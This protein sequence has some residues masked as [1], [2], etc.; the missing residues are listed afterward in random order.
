M[1]QTILQGKW[2]AGGKLFVPFH[3]M[4]STPSAD[5][6]K[7]KSC[8]MRRMQNFNSGVHANISDRYLQCRSAVHA[9]IRTISFSAIS[10]YM[11]CARL[12]CIHYHPPNHC[13]CHPSYIV[14][15]LRHEALVEPASQSTKDDS[16]NSVF[17]AHSGCSI[18]TASRL[19]R[20]QRRKHPGATRGQ[21]GMHME[22][23]AETDPKEGRDR[24]E[25]AWCDVASA[26]TCVLVDKPERH[27]LF[28]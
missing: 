18:R 7:A 25:A 14:S 4:G 20:L 21:V 2:G 5:L 6:G 9:D 1:G 3:K 12:Y 19:L 24:P 28:L 16:S 17:Q 22:S 10:C 26:R 13:V 8:I 23:D 27:I 11:R 15:A